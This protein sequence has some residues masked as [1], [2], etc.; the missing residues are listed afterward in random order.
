MLFRSKS[1]TRGSND[2]MVPMGMISASVTAPGT[3]G[4]R[5]W[6]KS[7]LWRLKRDTSWTAFL[8]DKLRLTT[9]MPG[10]AS[11]GCWKL[12]N[13]RCRRKA[14]WLTALPHSQSQHFRGLRF[15][16][17]VLRRNSHSLWQRTYK[18]KL[19]I[20][21]TIANLLEVIPISS[22]PP[23][24]WQRVKPSLRPAGRGREWLRGAGSRRATAVC[25]WIR[26]HP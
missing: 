21:S 9:E 22:T 15:A 25:W 17:Q 8:A 10:C 4:F 18:Y 24:P 7:R 12:S 2:R 1:M 6:N 19:Y 3:C 16:G 13:G 11:Y 20:P 23:F 26:T 5:A 14:N